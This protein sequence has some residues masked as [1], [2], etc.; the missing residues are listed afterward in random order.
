[1]VEN[2]LS[3]LIGFERGKEDIASE[4]SCLAHAPNNRHA[5][6]AAIQVFPQLE[7][8]QVTMSLTISTSRVALT[9]FPVQLGVRT[10]E[11]YRLF[12]MQIGPIYPSLSVHL[13]VP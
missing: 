8:R 7:L 3:L 1:M 11:F 2:L 9:S 6:S 12:P 4:H 10:R 13:Y 5:I